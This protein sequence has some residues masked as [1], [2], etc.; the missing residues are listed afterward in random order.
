VIAHEYD[1][2]TDVGSNDGT[3]VDSDADLS[4]GELRRIMDGLID[5]KA[6]NLFTLCD[7]TII[8]TIN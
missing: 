1:S 7:I 8:N 2:G 3:V 6:W 4:E 5:K